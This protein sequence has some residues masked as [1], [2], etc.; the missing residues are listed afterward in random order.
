MKEGEVEVVIYHYDGSDGENSLEY[1][2]IKTDTTYTYTD[3]ERGHEVTEQKNPI[4]KRR[5]WTYKG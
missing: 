5:R 2:L 4:S 1:L 3:R